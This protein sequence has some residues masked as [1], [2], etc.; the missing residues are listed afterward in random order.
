MMQGKSTLNPFATPYVPL[1]KLPFETRDGSSEKTTAAAGNNET[2]ENSL[3]HQL[4]ES[5]SFNYD[6]QSFQKLSLSGESSSKVGEFNNPTFPDDLGKLD[7]SIAIL[8][9][10]SSAFPDISLDYLSELLA[11]NQ[12]D[13]N[14]T[15]DALQ[16]FESDVDALD[17]PTELAAATDGSSDIGFH[18][19]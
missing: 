3:E 11:I 6:I 10:L 12:G 19:T 17:Y 14:D 18:S 16:Q 5:F 4:P 13:F 2:T 15:I 7:D 8:D 9:C 1:T